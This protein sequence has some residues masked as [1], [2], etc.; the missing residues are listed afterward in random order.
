[1][2]KL[3]GGSGSIPI[4]GIDGIWAGVLWGA[5]SASQRSFTN[6][7]SKPLCDIPYFSASSRNRFT[8]SWDAL[9]V[10]L[11]SMPLFTSASI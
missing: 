6:I 2:G 4:L 10:T 1:L 5:F 7:V 8:V 3:G 11:V 9:Y